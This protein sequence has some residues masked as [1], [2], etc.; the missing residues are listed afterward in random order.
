M[1]NSSVDPD[2][3]ITLTL[4]IRKEESLLRKCDL[5]KETKNQKEMCKKREK[6]FVNNSQSIPISF[7][8]RYLFYYSLNTPISG[9]VNGFK[10]FF[11][12]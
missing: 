6:R 1:K 11:F 2:V 12:T 7:S 10:W 8:S 4:F 9:K 3:N 5:T